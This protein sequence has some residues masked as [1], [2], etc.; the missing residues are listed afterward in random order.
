VRLP[1][2][3]RGSNPDWAKRR[4][5]WCLT[6]GFGS[7][8]ACRKEEAGCPFF[9][10]CTKRRDRCHHESSLAPQWFDYCVL[11]RGTKIVQIP[12][13]TTSFSSSFLLEERVNTRHHG[14]A[15]LVRL[16]GQLPGGGDEGRLLAALIAPDFMGPLHADPPRRTL[17]VPMC[18][19]QSWS[20]GDGLGNPSTVFIYLFIFYF[21]LGGVLR[22]L[23]GMLEQTPCPPL[24]SAVTKEGV[25]KGRNLGRYST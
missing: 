23:A 2:D 4:S 12:L 17:T 7:R 13:L 21:F 10:S 25:R 18:S 9:L 3:C 6:A 14:V 22:F 24:Q 5:K 15:T 11:K 1:N 19:C 16:A 8:H 20:E